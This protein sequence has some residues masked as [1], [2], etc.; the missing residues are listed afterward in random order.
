MAPGAAAGLAR[1]LLSGA[2]MDEE[3]KGWEIK[4]HAVRIMKKAGIY[5][6]LTHSEQILATDLDEYTNRITGECW[7]SLDQIG[8]ATGLSKHTVIKARGLLCERGLLEF[9]LGPA[10]DRFGRILYHGKDVMHYRWLP[11]I[12]GCPGMSQMS[13]TYPKGA[14]RMPQGCNPERSGVQSGEWMIKDSNR[15]ERV[16]LLH[17]LGRGTLSSSKSLNQDSAASGLPAPEKKNLPTHEEEEPMK[18]A[19]DRLDPRLLTLARNYR[20][21]QGRGI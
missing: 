4:C 15:D 20:P 13:R 8:K 7:R 2:R 11:A 3:R 17:P 12:Q 18:P 16:Q 21:G 14:D 10:I 19:I 1:V 5:R 6:R 9:F